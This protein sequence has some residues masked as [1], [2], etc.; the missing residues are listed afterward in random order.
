ML[1]VIER[2]KEVLFCFS[3]FEHQHKW[4]RRYFSSNNP[5]IEPKIEKTTRQLNY[6][7][8]SI[9]LAVRDEVF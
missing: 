5:G 6:T 8:I 1:G 7:G 3:F 2:P 9:E 4:E